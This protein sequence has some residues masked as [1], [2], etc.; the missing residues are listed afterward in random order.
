PVLQVPELPPKTVCLVLQ[1]T[2]L[3]SRERQAA[4]QL[5]DA[6]DVRPHFP[7]EHEPDEEESGPED[8]RPQREKAVSEH[9][10]PPCSSRTPDP[11]FSIGAIPVAPFTFARTSRLRGPMDDPRNQRKTTSS[12]EREGRRRTPSGVALERS[13]RKNQAPIIGRHARE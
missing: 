6:V 5:G 13:Q 4:L 12:R 7:P 2:L 9:G 10:R 3:R 11:D 8:Q 1:P